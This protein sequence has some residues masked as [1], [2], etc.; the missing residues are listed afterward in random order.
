[1]GGKDDFRKNEMIQRKRRPIRELGRKGPNLFTTANLFCGVYALLSVFNKEYVGAATAILVAIVFDALDGKLARMTKTTSNFGLEYDSLSDL[2][3]F[4]VA[5]GFLV[6]SLGLNVYGRL[7][8][9]ALFLYIACGALRLARFNIY[10]TATETKGF[11][12]LPI[13]AAAA[14]VSA[15][16]IL[17]DYILHFGKELRPA[18][19]VS[20]T[21]LLAFLMVST[22][23]YRNFK[24]VHLKDRIPFSVLVVTVLGLLVLVVAPQVMFFCIAL[25]YM[26]SGI[27][28]KPVVALYRTIRKGAEEPPL[29]QTR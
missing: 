20:I 16:V 19:I 7:G 18:V 6:Y 13:P 27:I 26:L 8:W 2:V 17:D 28:E 15:L 11:V 10:S 12:G 5:P 9:A 21:Y 3:S 24:E 25:L 29:E 23:P 4:G 22:I 1:M 14:L